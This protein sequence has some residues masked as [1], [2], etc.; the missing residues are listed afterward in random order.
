MIIQPCIVNVGAIAILTI[1]MSTHKASGAPGDQ[2]S[3]GPSIIMEAHWPFNTLHFITLATVL[4]NGGPPVHYIIMGPI[5]RF[6]TL[7]WQQLN[8]N[9]G[10]SVHYIIMGPIGLKVYITCQY[11]RSASVQS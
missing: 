9:G 6:N 11:I 3:N 5:G 2:S 1:E 4:H 8:H 10:P 7:H